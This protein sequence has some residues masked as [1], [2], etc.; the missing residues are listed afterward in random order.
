MKQVPCRSSHHKEE[1]AGGAFSVRF[2]NETR[3]LA[4]IGGLH[5]KPRKVLLILKEG[6]LVGSS[7]GPNTPKLRT[8]PGRWVRSLL[9]AFLGTI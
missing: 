4:V 6:S 1:E 3:R 2:T 5:P 9:K 8:G 7:I